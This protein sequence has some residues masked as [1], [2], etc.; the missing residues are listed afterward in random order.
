MSGCEEVFSA[1]LH[2]LVEED[3][4]VLVENAE[5]HGFGVQIDSAVVGVRLGVESHGSLL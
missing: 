1:A 2:V 3:L 4:A 5:V